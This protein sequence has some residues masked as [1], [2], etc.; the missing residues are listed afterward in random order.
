MLDIAKRNLLVSNKLAGAVTPHSV[1]SLNT[2]GQWAE[3]LNPSDHVSL[4]KFCMQRLAQA[5]RAALNDNTSSLQTCDLAVG[6]TLSTAHNGTGVA[7]AP[8]GRRRDT[9]NE[10]DNGLVHG[11]V[12]LQ[13]F[14][15]VLFCAA[16]DLTDHDDSVRLLVSE[17]SAQAVDE[18][19]AGERVSSN[20]NNKALPKTGLGGLVNGFVGKSSR[21]RHNTD[22]P[23][24]VNETWHNANLALAGSDDTRAVGTDKTCLALRFE[25]IGDADHV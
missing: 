21:S 17:E 20:A 25:D 16:S 7:H 14:G 4:D 1:P 11:V 5:G 23:A 18:V 6:I 8:A 24:L 12:C 19:C 9:S 2:I 10:A 13:V 15:G 3:T 22:A